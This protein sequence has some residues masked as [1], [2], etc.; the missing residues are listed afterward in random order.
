MTNNERMSE[1]Y[2]DMKWVKQSLSDHFSHHQKYEVALA[3]GV[4]L[5]IIGQAIAYLIK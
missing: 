1:L 5:A 2:T 4:L 3:T